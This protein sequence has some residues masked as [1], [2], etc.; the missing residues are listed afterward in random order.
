MRKLIVS[1]LVT[2]D[3]HTV[4][5]RNGL[6]HIRALGELVQPRGYVHAQFLDAGAR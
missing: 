3:G 4:V 5:G 2:L 6:P 1:T